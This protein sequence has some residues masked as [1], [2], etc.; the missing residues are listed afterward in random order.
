MVRG[1]W[2]KKWSKRSVEEKKRDIRRE[3]QCYKRKVNKDR[4]E[5]QTNSPI[6]RGDVKEKNDKQKESLANSH[7]NLK[8]KK[9]LSIQ[10]EY[11]I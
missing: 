5:K 1:Q 8:K 11:I 2:K 7:V 6:C 4:T 9:K 10:N 3:T